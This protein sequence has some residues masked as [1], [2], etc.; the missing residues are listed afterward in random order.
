MGYEYI[1]DSSAWIEYFNGSTK[2][3]KIKNII[4]EKIIGTSILAIVE[5]ADK[6]ERENKNFEDELN[7]IKS[8]ASIIP[9]SINIAL[10]SAKIKKEFRI[11]NSKFGIA[12]SIHI[13]TSKSENSK[14]ITS[15]NDFMPFKNIILI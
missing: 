2:G 14:F 3:E 1:I 7:F 15:D 4:E 10:E 5:L 8:R 9:I 13:A 6:F 12:D 11:K